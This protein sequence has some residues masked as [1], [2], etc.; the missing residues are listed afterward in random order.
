MG[1]SGDRGAGTGQTLSLGPHLRKCVLK[2]FEVLRPNFFTGAFAD[3]CQ[4]PDFFRSDHFQHFAESVGLIGM[5]AD[6]GRDGAQVRASAEIAALRLLRFKEGGLRRFQ[7]GRVIARSVGCA[8]FTDI[9][10]TT[11]RAILQTVLATDA[12]LSPVE[13]GAI[14]Q[15][16]DG[17]VGIATA[18]NAN[19]DRLLIT[20]KATAKLHRLTHRHAETIPARPSG[21]GNSVVGLDAVS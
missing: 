21:G 17:L 6:C 1:A 11:S 19:E 2:L 16:V 4:W 3:S 9:M 18:A 12:S 13:R 20:Q 5:D 10:N 8:K 15:T 14:Q 7:H